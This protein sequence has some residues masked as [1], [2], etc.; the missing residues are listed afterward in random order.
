MT[1]EHLGR[2]WPSLMA[3]W[4]LLV[5]GMACNFGPY[6]LAT[7]T[8][9]GSNDLALTATAVLAT[10]TQIAVWRTGTAQASAATSA[11]ALL[12][13]TPVTPLPTDAPIP[14]PSIATTT[15]PPPA[16]GE[17]LLAYTGEILTLYNTARRPI[18]IA[19]LSFHSETGELLASQWD[20]GYLTASLYAFP[21]GDCLMAWTL[22]TPQQARPTDCNTRH[23]WIAVNA[24]Q[25]FWRA[26]N[27]FEVRNYGQ[28]LT[29]CPGGDGTCAI[30]LP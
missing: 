29:Q 27:G 12:P 8:P 22:E 16:E 18:D 23:A 1:S 30:R 11:P 4:A 14:A 17:V 15:A 9:P 25:S 21:P 26:A 3:L 5:A 19:G 20:N 7:S 6:H 28:P 24:T 10:N 13:T 2:G